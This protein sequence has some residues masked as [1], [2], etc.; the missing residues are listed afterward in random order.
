MVIITPTGLEDFFYSIGTPAIEKTPPPADPV[1]IN[2]LM[3]LAQ[4][5]HMDI[6]LPGQK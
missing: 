6:I 4:S 3:Q 5:Y 2:K 1:D